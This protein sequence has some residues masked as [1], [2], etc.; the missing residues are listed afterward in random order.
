ML[1]PAFVLVASFAYLG[2]LFAIA[3]W[4]ERCAAAG[5]SVIARPSVYALSLAVYATSWTFYASVGRA[6]SSGVG[7]LPISSARR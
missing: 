5:R 2:L 3:H 6:A 4:G 7:F 1:E